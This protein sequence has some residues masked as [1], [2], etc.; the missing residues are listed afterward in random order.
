MYFILMPA[1]LL[2]ISLAY[3]SSKIPNMKNIF[4]N[5]EIKKL[6][7]D[8]WGLI[9]STARA[10]RYRWSLENEYL[11]YAQVTFF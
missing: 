4:C 6:I 11:S 5:F 3:E 7:I 9:K 1:C 2:F 8:W 10:Y